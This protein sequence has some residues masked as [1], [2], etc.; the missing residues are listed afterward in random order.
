ME[1]LRN[2]FR[3][4]DKRKQGGLSVKVAIEGGGAF[5]PL[6]VKGRKRGKETRLVL[7]SANRWWCVGREERGLILPTIYPFFVQC[8][9]QQE[10][11]GLPNLL[12]WLPPPPPP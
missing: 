9:V 11:L 4:G 3:G 5:V 8:T 10:R 12:G 1:D 2:P 6:G 7:G